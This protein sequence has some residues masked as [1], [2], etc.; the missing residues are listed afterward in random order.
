M[1]LTML[2]PLDVLLLA[3]RAVFLLLSF[4]IAAIT[5]SA[6]RRAARRQT[7]EILAQSQ[8]L[9]ER[10]AAL[11]TRFDATAAVLTRID[12]RTER[13]AHL[14]NSPAADYQVATR[15]ARGG[16]S[17]EE[18]MSRCGLSLAEAELVRRLHGAANRVAA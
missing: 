9:L 17:R 11:E 8:S 1:N 14:S 2:P 10:L 16:A 15:L 3:A 12:E 13:L 18:L 7:G 4:V 6:W 5:F